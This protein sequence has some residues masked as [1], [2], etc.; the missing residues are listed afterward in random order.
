MEDQVVNDTPLDDKLLKKTG[1][2]WKITGLVI[3]IVFLVGGLLYLLLARKS[4][5]NK[6]MK[7]SIT[8]HAVTNKH[9][10]G[11]VEEVIKTGSP[12][13]T[14]GLSKSDDLNTLKKEMDSTS[15]DDFNKDID[16]VT[17]DLNNL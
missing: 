17:S 16:S 13:P 10:N 8:K 14:Q 15:I 5:L 7:S 3:L 9:K 4:K 6:T 1:F 11:T 2:P 12:V